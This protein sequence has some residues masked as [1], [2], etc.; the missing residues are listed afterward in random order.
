L[1]EVIGSWKIIEIRFPPDLAHLRLVEAEQVGALEQ[2]FAADDPA[3]RFA[4][5]A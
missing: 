4:P 3:R 5:A 1:S 2:D